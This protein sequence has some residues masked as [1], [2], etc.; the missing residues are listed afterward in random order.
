VPFTPF[1]L[2]PGAL[3]KA[4]GGHR[5]SFT[6]FAGS[7]VLMD[8]EPLIR[9]ARG[10]AILH[11]MTHTVFG[12]FAISCV[13]VVIGVPASNAAL[14]YIGIDERV[15]WTI[16]AA[17]ALI[18]TYSHVAFDALMHSDMQPF[19]PLA[20]GNPLLGLVGLRALHAACLGAGILGALVMA[21]RIARRA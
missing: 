8:V 19:W 6:I 9:I 1:H 12:A 2:G 7:Q 21:A 5:F 20:G 14:R 11:G 10:D 15:G 13:S 16:A 18:G 17:S 4:V 3:F